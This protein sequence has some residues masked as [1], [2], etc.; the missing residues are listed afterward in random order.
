[1]E[2]DFPVSDREKSRVDATESHLIGPTP[3]KQ[4]THF[5]Q[6]TNHIDNLIRQEQNQEKGE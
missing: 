5:K 1:M 2:E 3:P 6:L 4:A